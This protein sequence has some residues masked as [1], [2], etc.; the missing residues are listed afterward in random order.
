MTKSAENGIFIFISSVRVGRT[1][2]VGAGRFL[3]CVVHRFHHEH[4]GNGGCLLDLRFVQTRST[5]TICHFD[6][7]IYCLLA[8]VNRLCR[9]I[10]FMSG[11]RTGLYWR[12]CWGL[13]TP[14]VMITI[15]LYTFITFKPLTYRGYVYP[16]MAY[17][18]QHSSTHASEFYRSVSFSRFSRLQK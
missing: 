14:A 3:R 13:I 5:R 18:M 12:L 7:C 4:C 9:D 6:V 15:L 8:G 1:I 11:R 10:E 17:G 2:Y 16:D